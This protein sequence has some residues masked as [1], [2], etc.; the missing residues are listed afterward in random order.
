MSERIL[1]VDDE[2]GIRSTLSA[3]LEDEGY[4]ATAVGTAGEAAG[5][6]A[7]ETW[8]A[9]LLDLWLPDRDG[10][11]L[12]EELRDANPVPVIVISG[13]GNIDTAVKATRLGAYDF[14]EK[15]LSLSRVVLTVQ[16]A[17]ERGRLARELRQLSDRLERAEPLLG[18]TPVMQRL[19]AELKIVAPSDSRILILGENGTG[20]ELVARQVH[21]LSRRAQGP[22]VEVN[23]AAIPEDLIE[24]E[25]FGHVKGAFTGAIGDR[26]GRFEQADGGT[27]FLDEIADMSEKTQA[28][29]LRVLQE[30]RFERV[31]GTSP[32]RVDVR[33]L[34]A[35]NKALEEEIR[36]GRFRE[37]LYFRLAVIPLRVPPLRERSDDLS[38]LVTHFVDVFA[39]ELG[40]RPKAVGPE[41][42]ARLREYAWPG[43][44]RELRNL[45]ERMMIMTPG[46]TIGLH[47]L[48]P[49]LRAEAADPSRGVWDADYPS[50]REA[51]L[52]FEKH[53]I[54]RK[55]AELEG[56][57][58]KT[59]LAVGLERSNLYRKMRAYGI[60]VE[61]ESGES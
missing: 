25:L 43:N 21:R 55:L 46:E 61:R 4:R 7:S 49:A 59:A 15:P 31:G 20:K 40:R 1:I 14:L 17:L 45:V 39:K 5:R 6:L 60:E 57:V 27:L 34:A 58:S 11:E 42:M 19:K 38:L 8:D 22:F 36:Q 24:S 12:L 47:D 3:I 29:V 41:A 16:N 30:Q 18:S 37:D 44:V 28:K 35:T 10:M 56:N 48:P 53:Y 23:C 26:S 13:H 54:E 52:A 50:L 51:R 33:V 9:V 32:I 2:A